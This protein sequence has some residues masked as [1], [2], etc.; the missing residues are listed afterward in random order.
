VGVIRTRFK[1]C[2]RLQIYVLNCRKVG[3]EVFKS[4]FEKG[5]LMGISGGYIKSPLPPFFKG[6]DNFPVQVLWL[7]QNEAENQF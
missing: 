4:P 2:L 1:T 7:A 5:G 3:T 6:G